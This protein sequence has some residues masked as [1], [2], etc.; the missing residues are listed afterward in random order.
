[1][2]PDKLRPDVANKTKTNTVICSYECYKFVI[3][4]NGTMGYTAITLER[5]SVVGDK[6]MAITKEVIDGIIAH[7]EEVKREW[8]K[9]YNQAVKDDNGEMIQMLL[10]SAPKV[11]RA[12]DGAIRIKKGLNTYI[13]ADE[14]ASRKFETTGDVEKDLAYAAARATVARK[15]N[16]MHKFILTVENL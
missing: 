10:K 6:R 16:A 9:A 4:T 8:A 15:A 2:T 11:K 14:Q 5:I 3:D 12:S 13:Q 7:E 1:M